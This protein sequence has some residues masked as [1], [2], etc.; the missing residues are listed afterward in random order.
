MG[1]VRAL[2]TLDELRSMRNNFGVK[3][4]PASRLSAG[5]LQPSPTAEDVAPTARTPAAAAAQA[6]TLRV[7]QRHVADIALWFD[8]E[9]NGQEASGGACG[10]ERV[11]DSSLSSAVKA[12]YFETWGESDGHLGGLDLLLTLCAIPS[13]S[14]PATPP[15][16]SDVTHDRDQGELYR[17]RA[18]CTWEPGYVRVAALLI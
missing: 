15:A 7:A 12:V 10:G 16:S 2:P 11:K 5:G 1:H 17:R 13:D 4:S 6:D 18:G 3:A 8:P 9:G 14:V